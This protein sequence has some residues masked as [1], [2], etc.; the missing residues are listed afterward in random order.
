MLKA[1]CWYA[2]LAPSGSEQGT[3]LN[4]TGEDP[5]LDDLPLHK[6]LIIS[7]LT[8]EVRHCDCPFPCRAIAQH[9]LEQTDSSLLRRHC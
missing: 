6:E 8:K 2:V 1:V 3:L 9:S 4:L 7:F 5:R